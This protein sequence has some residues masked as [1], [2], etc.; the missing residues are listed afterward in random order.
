VASASAL[1]DRFSAAA[2]TVS[3][4]INATTTC[5]HADIDAYMEL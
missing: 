4:L 2:S 3:A 5:P 1:D